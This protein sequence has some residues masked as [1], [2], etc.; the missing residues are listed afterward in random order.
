MN[1]DRLILLSRILIVA[2]T[3]AL[4]A[5]LFTWRKWEKSYLRWFPLY[6]LVIVLLELFNRIMEYNSRFNI[7]AALNILASFIEINFASFFF[8]QTL[9]SKHKKWVVAGIIIYLLSFVAEKIFNRDADYFFQSLSYT[10]GNLFIL[11]YL[12]L[13]YIELVQSSRLL[14]FYKLTVFWIASGMLI[15]YLGSFPFYGLFNVLAK[16]LDLFIV[17]AWVATSL[18]YTMYLLFTIAFIWGKPQ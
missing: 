6:L 15:F 12:I 5:G 7:S 4:L 14:H 18:N 9:E 13:F 2:E 11:I 3:L 16:N 1:Q 10:I 8:Y 17:A